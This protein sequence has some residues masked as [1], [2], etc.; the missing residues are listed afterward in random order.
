VK[1]TV[2]ALAG[3]WTLTGT[4]MEPAARTPV[5]VK[6]TVDCRRAALGAAVSCLITADVSDTHVEAAS[7]IGYSPDE[8]VVRW[9]EIS[10]AGEYHDHRGPW[11]GTEIQF[12]PLTYTISGAMMTEYFAPSFPSPGRMIWK[13]RVE[14]SEGTSRIELTG[15]R[16]STKARG[17][18]QGR[19]L[20]MTLETVVLEDGGTGKG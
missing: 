3:Y 13:W 11:K 12:E 4:D 2:D 19:P 9:M 8:H 15:T 16:G 20:A 14:T 18:L 7:V 1:K 17:T 6:A 5:S 10:S